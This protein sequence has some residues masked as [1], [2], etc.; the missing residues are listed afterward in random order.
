MKNEE[1]IRM[2]IAGFEIKAK[3]IQNTIAELNRQLRGHDA[4]VKVAKR[5]RPRK[6][7]V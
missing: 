4:P 7:S 6:V 5:G 1:L 3:E 2:A